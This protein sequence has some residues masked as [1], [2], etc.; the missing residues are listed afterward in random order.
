MRTARRSG[1]VLL[2]VAAACSEVYVEGG[3]SAT[4]GVGGG[5]PDEVVAVA[6]G[7][8]STVG[9]G[10]TS[11]GVTVVSSSGAGG[12][13]VVCPSFNEPCT[14]CIATECAATW[15]D[16][17]GN[18]ECFALFACAG[19]CMDAPGCFEG[20]MT[21]HPEGIAA[22]L[23]VSGCAGTTCDAVCPWGSDDHTPCAGC[24]FKDCATE[25]NACFGKPDCFALWQCFDGCG[26]NSLSC[27]KQC[28]EKHPSG[29]TE[30]EALLTCADSSCGAVCG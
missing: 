10:G 4:T 20:C 6:V 24:V 25:T 21:K 2:L 11:P 8:S 13:E 14:G 15:C 18:A 12:D 30:L 29:V 3:T 5:P 7:P 9:T 17:Q 27:H 23:S 28:Y 26:P 1:V 16:C 22:L 19:D